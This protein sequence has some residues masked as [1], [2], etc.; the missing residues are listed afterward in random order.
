MCDTISSN[1]SLSKIFA[2]A[3]SISI[4]SVPPVSSGA[5]WSSL[6][7]PGDSACTATPQQQLLIIN[8]H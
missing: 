6:V 1:D 5:S 8:Y 7:A 4:V 3:S 2:N